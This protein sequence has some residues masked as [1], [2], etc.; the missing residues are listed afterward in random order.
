[1]ENIWRRCAL[2]VI[3]LLGFIT[4]EAGAAAQE[5]F[6]AE[7]REMWQRLG[8]NTSIPK[9]GRARRCVAELV[10]AFADRIDGINRNRL[11]V[12]CAMKRITDA[13]LGIA[14]EGKRKQ[15]ILDRLSQFITRELE[16][17]GGY[18][19]LQ[20]LAL[21]KLM[22]MTNLFGYGHNEAVIMRTLTSIRCDIEELANIRL[23]VLVRSDTARQLMDMEEET[24]CLEKV[25]A[26]GK[27]D[28]GDRGVILSMKKVQLG[29]D[30][31]MRN[32]ARALGGVVSKKHELVRS[33]NMERPVVWT[34]TPCSEATAIYKDTAGTTRRLKLRWTD[35]TPE[36][37]DDN[38]FDL[39][40]KGGIARARDE[41]FLI[42]ALQI[43]Y[44]MQPDLRDKIMNYP[45]ELFDEGSPVTLV[46]RVFAAKEKGDA[47]KGS[48]FITDFRAKL[49]GIEWYE[50][51]RTGQQ[52]MGELLG[53]LV[54]SLWEIFERVDGIGYSN[55]T[56]TYLYQQTVTTEYPVTE[57]LMAK[58]AVNRAYGRIMS[59]GLITTIRSN[60]I[61]TRLEQVGYW[62]MMRRVCD[63]INGGYTKGPGP[64]EEGYIE[65]GISDQ[66]EVGEL[67]HRIADKLKFEIRAA[68]ELTKREIGSRWK[69]AIK[70]LEGQIEH[71]DAN[72]AEEERYKGQVSQAILS[73]DVVHLSVD[74]GVGAV[75]QIVG[76]ALEHY[77][78]RGRY[79]MKATRRML[80][81]PT[82]LRVKIERCEYDVM[83]GVTGKRYNTLN[84]PDTVKMEIGDGE[85]VEYELKTVAIHSGGATYGH[86]YLLNKQ[87]Q[88]G[89]GK[90]MWVEGNDGNTS[91]IE[92]W[93]A[94]AQIN[95]SYGDQ[96][97]TGVYAVYVRTR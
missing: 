43:I 73:N 90:C 18:I 81:I 42:T 93:R 71:L 72:L 6:A 5:G 68:L 45:A 33:M 17:P 76:A 69:D 27:M 77:D 56:S 49:A 97:G 80:T 9:E 74:Q 21:E 15:T 65:P 87:W 54:S 19:F 57:I 37:E 60:P 30:A 86:Y 38:T 84:M 35:G 29:Q 2:G 13:A 89:V 47:C 70:E 25:Y 36:L 59:P 3:A 92:D 50:E 26:S 1:M 66:V 95:A 4:A 64:K 16:L 63:E 8:R 53:A 55:I 52:D 28:V 67:S 75:E 94:W 40:S 44:H 39:A 32:I 85:V 46:R 23:D 78:G 41:C 91:K 31:V 88:D 51:Y 61:I 10:T 48:V 83:T 82:Y 22:E 62:K 14:E 11:P 7:N 79:P 12:V 58:E 34:F 96:G 24:Q 20:R